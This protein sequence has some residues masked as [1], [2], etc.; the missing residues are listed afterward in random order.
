V[1]AGTYL[2]WLWT[3]S[4]ALGLPVI[5]LLQNF[6]GNKP[7]VLYYK[8]GAVQFISFAATIHHQTTLLFAVTTLDFHHPSNL[9]MLLK[10]HGVP[11]W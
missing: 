6:S 1:T 7:L 10:L 11:T 8:R 3:E 5:P 2:T 4:I 9:F